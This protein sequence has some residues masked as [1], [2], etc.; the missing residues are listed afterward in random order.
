MQFSP[1][2]SQT[3]SFNVSLTIFQYIYYH[4]S[5]ISIYFYNSNS[6]FDIKNCFFLH[7]RHLS[8]SPIG[9]LYIL[10]NYLIFQYNY[11]NNCTCYDC[12]GVHFTSNLVNSNCY[13]IINS[14]SSR[15][16]GD[17]FH[18]I[19]LTYYNNSN[20]YS[21]QN[22][23]FRSYNSDLKFINCFNNSSPSGFPLQFSNSTINYSNIIKN[24]FGNSYGLIR[25]SY[26]NSLLSFSIIKTNI[27]S[28]S[29]SNDQGAKLKINNIYTDFSNSIFT[30]CIIGENCFF[31]QIDIQ[32]L[33]WV[34]KCN[35]LSTSNFCFL[36]FLFF[37]LFILQFLIIY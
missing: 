23:I 33:K 24:L 10:S 5:G 11:I 29:F 32:N 15:L 37:N 17:L 34:E 26:S 20:N 36:N 22:G 18:K 14:K 27:G 6:N 28:S 2:I 25:L 19:I 3:N 12:S 7:N 35:L 9:I 4:L 30:N 1:R 16:Y 8:G 21:P 13:S 31:S